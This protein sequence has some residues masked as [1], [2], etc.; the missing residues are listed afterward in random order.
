MTERDLY[1]HFKGRWLYR[2]NEHFLENSAAESFA[3]YAMDKGWR[4]LGIDGFVLT[5]K[6]TEPLL[7]VIA[8]YSSRSPSRDDVSGFLKGGAN[9]TH[10]SFV[11][12]AK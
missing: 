11:L 6:T 2:G 3:N 7:D 1:E 4:I 12:A 5:D 10:F 9:A 8:D